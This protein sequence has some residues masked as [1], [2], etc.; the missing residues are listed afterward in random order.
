MDVNVA[1]NAAVVRKHAVKEIEHVVVENA[2]M[3]R[4]MLKMKSENVYF[5]IY[6]I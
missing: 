2:A 3:E 4:M 1:L 5:I 6:S